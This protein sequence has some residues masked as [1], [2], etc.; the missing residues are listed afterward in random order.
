MTWHFSWYDVGRF[1]LTIPPNALSSP[2]FPL[3]S[4]PFSLSSRLWGQ[5]PPVPYTH[6]AIRAGASP[7]T[8]EN[9]GRL[10]PRC[11]LQWRQPTPE[12]PAQ[13]MSAHG[14]QW[15]ACGEQ[16]TASPA[17]GIVCWPAKWWV[18]PPNALACGIT[19]LSAA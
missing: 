16:T 10:P 3:F 17:D 19:L 6:R 11:L 15:V 7:L 2:F 18:H 9:R 12:P 13:P 4:Y 5:A 8:P 14:A 1:L